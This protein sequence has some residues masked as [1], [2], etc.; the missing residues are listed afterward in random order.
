MIVMATAAVVAV[1]SLA[2]GPNAGQA[3][4]SQAPRRAGGNPDLSGIWQANNTANWD[5]ETHVA[6]PAV[7][8]PG[9]KVSA[10]SDGTFA[11]TN[12]RNGFSKT[13]RVRSTS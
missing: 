3:P 11:V 5:L 4:T 7:A 2:G 9:V 6:R 1:L 10:Q 12:S 13:Y 8:Q